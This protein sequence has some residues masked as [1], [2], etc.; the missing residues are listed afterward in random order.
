M[1]K[2]SK[3]VP[4]QV[5]AVSILCNHLELAASEIREL[6]KQQIPQEFRDKPKSAPI[7]I[8]QYFPKQL[9]ELL[10]FEEQEKWIKVSPKRFLGS[11][12]FARIA[13]IVRD[14]GGEYV[15]AGKNSHFKIP[16][17]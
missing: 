15:S 3:E 17:A 6:L 7:Q 9:E 12:N 16:K 5:K 8:R 11:E 10:S 13:T 4:L 14:L 2:E 1:N